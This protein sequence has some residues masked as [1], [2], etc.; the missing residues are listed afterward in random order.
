[1]NQRWEPYQVTASYPRSRSWPRTTIS[2]GMLTSGGG[3]HGRGRGKPTIAGVGLGRSRD[4]ANFFPMRIKQKKLTGIG[5]LAG[6]GSSLASIKKKGITLS[7]L[8][9]TISSLKLETFKVI[10]NYPLVR[11]KKVWKVGD[12]QLDRANSQ[13][14]L[15]LCLGC[16]A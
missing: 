9:L 13:T 5:F 10:R 14:T 7:I 2:A 4:F 3:L 12:E 1:M 6:F 16:V 15:E 11:L 8:A